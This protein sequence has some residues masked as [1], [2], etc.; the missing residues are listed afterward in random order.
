MEIVEIYYY[1]AAPDA[2]WSEEEFKTEFDAEQARARLND[3]DRAT[4]CIKTGERVIFST[5][6]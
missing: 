5:N 4:V 1:L 2:R 3:F 6:L